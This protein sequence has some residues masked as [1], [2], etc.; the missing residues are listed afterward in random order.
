LNFNELDIAKRCA[1]NE[2]AAQELLY[3]RFF[4]PMLQMCLRYTD[5]DKDRAL[6]ILNDGFL[7]VFKK[8]HLF[9]GRGS[10][11]GWIRRL[12]FH[13]V[14]DYYKANDA[15]LKNVVFDE[16]PIENQSN[17]VSKHDDTGGALG[18]LFFEDL[19]VLVD[20][21]PPA[22]REVFK[23]YA[24]EGFSHAEIG[25]QLNITTGTSKW[26]LSEAR[27]KLKVMLERRSISL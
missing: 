9:E 26:H 5:G 12:V 7:R 4:Q 22:T 3:R 1:A 18:K 15:Y 10:L 20:F 21:L 11:E 23:L 25:E 6:E 17:I 13:A 16:L 8:I 27:N 24:I 2:R 19:L 14:S